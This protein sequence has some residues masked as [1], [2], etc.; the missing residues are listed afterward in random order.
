MS[1]LTPLGIKRQVPSPRYFGF[2]SGMQD[3]TDGNAAILDRSGQGRHLLLGV[4]ATYATVTQN[5]QWATIVGAAAGQDRSLATASVLTWDL[6][7][8]QSL[9][10][11]A[12]LNAAPP[13]ATSTI[14]NAR[15]TGGDVKGMA[16][17]VDSTGRPVVFIRDTVATQATNVPTNILTDSTDHTV[18]VEI[19]GTAKTVQIRI[20]GTP[21]STHTTPQAITSTAGSTQSDDPAR[22]GGA[23]DFVAGSNPT[24]VSGANL[25]L[26]N[27]HLIVMPSWPANIADIRAELLRNPHRPISARL[28]P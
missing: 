22:W 12:T 15:G 8:G 10:L 6:F 14:F 13:G 16:L 5:S 11:Q 26:R 18:S 28:L 25:R 20:D 3:P 1:K 24:W 4:N 21:I 2:W 27:M 7:A 9:L 23:G 19:N 17:T